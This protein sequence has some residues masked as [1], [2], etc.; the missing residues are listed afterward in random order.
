MSHKEYVSNSKSFDSGFRHNRPTRI[1][2]TGFKLPGLRHCRGDDPN[3]PHGGVG[4]RPVR[5]RVWL[6]RAKPGA[7]R[8]HL[9]PCATMIS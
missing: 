7:K 8:P 4:V 6:L 9:E 1:T 5:H 2:P 3:A